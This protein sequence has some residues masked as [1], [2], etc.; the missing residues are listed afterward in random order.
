MTH[1]ELK[2]TCHKCTEQESLVVSLPIKHRRKMHVLAIGLPESETALVQ[3]FFKTKSVP[4][5]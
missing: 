3:G 4:R 5:T 2:Y 1:L